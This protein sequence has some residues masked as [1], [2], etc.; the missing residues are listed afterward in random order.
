LHFIFPEDILT[1]LALL[2][3]GV[4]LEYFYYNAAFA[5]GLT[6]LNL[7]CL[8]SVI[9]LINNYFPFL[10]GEINPSVGFEGLKVYFR[11]LVN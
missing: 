11:K 7:L 10:A 2:G 3:F 8:A 6:L 9:F 1:K 4:E 5:L